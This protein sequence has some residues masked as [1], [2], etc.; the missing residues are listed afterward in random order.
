LENGWAMVRD[1][2]VGPT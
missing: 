2:N 1:N